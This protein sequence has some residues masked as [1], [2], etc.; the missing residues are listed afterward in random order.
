MQLEKKIHEATS[1]HERI[2]YN[3]MLA[4]LE[5]KLA[6]AQIKYQ[7]DIRKV[8]DGFTATMTRN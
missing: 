8:R 4:E 3:L 5:V 6:R 1:E 2:R 7:E